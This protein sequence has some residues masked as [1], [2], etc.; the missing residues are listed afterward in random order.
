M[1]IGWILV[2]AVL[3]AGTG[4]GAGSGWMNV[5]PGGGAV[6]AITFD[7]HDPNTQ[8]IGSG[9]GLF[10]SIDG[11]TT[12][13]NTGLTGWSIPKIFLDPQN[14]ST[15]YVQAT[16][17]P[18]R[19]AET[20][21]KIFRSDDG[22]ATWN[23][24]VTGAT[25]MAVDPQVSG[26]LYALAGGFSQKG[27]FKSTDSGASWTLITGLPAGLG[28]F[29][30]AI[31][32][33]NHNTLYAAQMGT[34]SGRTVVT[35]Q[36]STD[37][38]VSWKA[39]DTGLPQTFDPGNGTIN[40]L[41]FAQNGI[42]ID[43]TNP[44]TIYAAKGGTGVYKSTDGGANWKAA[45]LG[46]TSSPNVPPCCNSGVVID[47]QNPNT[48]YATGGYPVNLMIYK[49]T[50]GGLSWSTILSQGAVG[51]QPL[52]IDPRG[53]LYVPI[54]SSL[55][56]S[57]DGGVTW[58]SLDVRLGA[59]VTALAIDPQSTLYAAGGN[60][61]WKSTDAGGS[62]SPAGVG[63]RDV[64]G[65]FGIP[66]EI[67]A[68]AVDTLNP[69]SLFAGV[70][71]GDCEDDTGTGVYASADGGTTWTDARSGIGCGV[72]AI[73]TDPQ[74]P[75][76]VYAANEYWGVYKSADGGISWTATRVPGTLALALDPGNSGT[77]YAATA[78]GVYKTTDGAA[79]WSRGLT[80]NALA[81]AVDAQSTVYVG[82]SAGVFQST[83]RGA[84]WQ[85]LLAGAPTAV[86][87]VVIDP[88]ASGTI[89]VG[90]DDGVL[91]SVDGGANW[92]AIAG[93]PE[94]V[95][96]LMLD[97]QNPGLLYAG[98]PGGLFQTQ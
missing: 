90:T 48:L 7:P 51:L 2:A 68:L 42:T 15:T 80:S 94:H 38:G 47:P 60:P 4:S 12:W 18:D 55:R 29:G 79:S 96:V 86:Y 36:K 25:L 83:D 53:A 41:P 14:T 64:T 57:T 76:T 52:F 66:Y 33:R 32:W 77:V 67:D 16:Y 28:T 63:I 24:L 8:Y 40:V 82:T 71:Y 84:S 10:K 43:P 78:G 26:T 46:M 72:T 13:N 59:V 92:T 6:S 88:R 61:L 89:Y 39:S 30:V 65:A 54:R 69:T 22:G 50:N 45:N 34:V 49:S 91:Q 58:N 44:N 27:L 70:N 56:K 87:A 73:V 17:L 3:A 74:N 21:N 85:N 20:I 19:D 1:K 98:G 93:G 23:D 11:G 81:V 75:G 62:W 97:Q 31:D 35:L 95:R 5:G 37:G 9:S